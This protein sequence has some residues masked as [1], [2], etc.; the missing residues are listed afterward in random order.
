MSRTIMSGDVTLGA[1]MLV[2]VVSK[3]AMGSDVVLGGAVLGC[4]VE[5]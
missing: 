4:G 5:N 1:V 3:V 2:Y